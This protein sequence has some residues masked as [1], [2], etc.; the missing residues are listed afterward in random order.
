MVFSSDPVL[1]I[2]EATIFQGQNS[3]L[4]NISFEIEKGEFVFIIGRTGSGKSSLL[5]TLYADLPLRLGDIDVAGF[6]I[7]GIKS[8]D[9]PLLECQSSLQIRRV[10]V[11]HRCTRDNLQEG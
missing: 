1:R 10:S 9:V 3:V 4:D 8:K 7:R 2:H 6:N 11:D 5:K